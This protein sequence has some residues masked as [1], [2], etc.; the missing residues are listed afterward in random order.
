[1]YDDRFDYFVNHIFPTLK[2]NYESSGHI[3][4]VV[5]AYNDFL[6]LRNH[7]KSKH[8]NFAALSEYTTNSNISRHRSNF[9]HGRVKY[10]IMTER[11][12]FYRR[13]LIRGVGHVV[14]YALPQYSWCYEELVNTMEAGVAGVTGSGLCVALYCV[15]DARELERVVGTQ[16]SLTMLSGD[17]TTHMFS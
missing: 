15:Y 17:R 12:Y 10:L 16:R 4:I 1:M 5:P 8:Y 3:M 9:Y 2:A 14:F 6:R 13:Y 11:F 7:F